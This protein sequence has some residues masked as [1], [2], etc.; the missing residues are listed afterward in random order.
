MNDED[1]RGFTDP[2]VPLTANRQ[3]STLPAGGWYVAPT[4]ENDHPP[5]EVPCQYDQ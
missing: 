2:A 3:P 4:C 1:A 5:P